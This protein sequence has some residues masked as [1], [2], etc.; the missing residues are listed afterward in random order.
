MGTAATASMSGRWPLFR[1][2]LTAGVTDG[3]RNAY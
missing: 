3:Y 1:E 2:R